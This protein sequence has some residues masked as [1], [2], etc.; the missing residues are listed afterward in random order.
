MENLSA[1]AHSDELIE[2]MRVRPPRTEAGTESRM[3][4]QRRAVASVSLNSG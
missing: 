2:W 1:R 3:R 4:S